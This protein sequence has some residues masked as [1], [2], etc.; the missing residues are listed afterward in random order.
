MLCAQV[1]GT[2]SAIIK[3]IAFG[4]MLLFGFAACSNSSH[5]PLG[6]ARFGTV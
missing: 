6:L 2:S 4:F 5:A 1:L 3:R